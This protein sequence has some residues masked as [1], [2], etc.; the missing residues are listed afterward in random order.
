MLISSDEISIRSSVYY[1]VY[2]YNLTL[3]ISYV[4]H[5]DYYVSGKEN[6]IMIPDMLY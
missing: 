2:L 3:S 1:T 4:S 5:R 6:L